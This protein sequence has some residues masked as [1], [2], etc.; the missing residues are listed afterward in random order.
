MFN[1]D[2]NYQRYSLKNW[3][4]FIMTDGVSNNFNAAFTLSR[5]SIDNPI[6][7]RQ[8]SSF[9]FSVESTLP[10]SLFTQKDYSK[11]SNAEKYEWLEYHKWKFKT[12]LFTPLTNNQKLVLMT[13]A[14]YGFL[15]YYDKNRRSPFQTFYMG[16]DGMSG[17][18]TTYATDI[19]GLRGYA[20]GSLT[21]Y[22]S[23][24][25]SGNV[26]T[27]L[28][29]ELHYPLVMEN[30]T[31]IYVLGFLEGGNCW[32]EL[33]QF[34]PFELKRS[35]GIGVRLFLPMFG[36][37]GVDWGYGY[38]QVGAYSSNSGSHFNFIIGQE[39]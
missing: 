13:R 39:F 28:T 16:G 36:L 24:G 5:N 37:M 33:N 19:I 8:G 21:P 17:A 22:T 27:R 30:S 12:K 26:Y 38:D 15:G 3:S 14:E 2:L 11:A 32:S 9:G 23:N 35:A 4:Y 18:S 29:M 7:T 1:V 25:Y 10:Y 31:T 20:N 6:Y 34:S